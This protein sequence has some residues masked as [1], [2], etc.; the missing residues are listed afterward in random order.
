LNLLGCVPAIPGLLWI[1]LLRLARLNRVGQIVRAWRPH[2]LSAVRAEFKAHRARSTLFVTLFVSFMLMVTAALV[3]LHV[4][5]TRAPEP[6]IVTGSDALWWAFV[7]ITTVGYGD[8][9]PTSEVGRVVAIVLMTTGIGIY[10]VLTSFV[11]SW[12]LGDD[13]GEPGGGQESAVTVSPQDIAGLNSDLSA[14]RKE[15]S[16]AQRE[17]ASIREVLQALDHRPGGQ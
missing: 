17:L 14:I 13:E 4:E 3:V 11:S 8:R 12:F 2:G 1:G 5:T 15:L 7:T 10:G 9:F 16:A 6:N